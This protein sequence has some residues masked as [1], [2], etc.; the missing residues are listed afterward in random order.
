ML[1]LILVTIFF[2]ISFFA[3]Y[4]MN[5]KYKNIL[6]IILVVLALEVYVFN[7]NSYRTFFKNFEKK[8]FNKE[9]FIL[10]NMEYDKQTD[11]FKI[12]KGEESNSIIIDNIY[13]EIATIKIEGAGANTN[14]IEYSINYTDLTSSNF[15]SMPKKVLV[16]DLEKSKYTTCYLSGESKKIKINFQQSD[17]E[18]TFLKIDSIKINEK[19]PFDFSI[20][21]VITLIAISLLIYGM[22]RCELFKKSYSERNIKQSLLFDFLVATFILITLWI[23]TTTQTRNN[24]YEKYIDALSQGQANLLD[25]PSQKLISLENPY[26]MTQRKEKKLEY[27]WDVALYNNKYYVYF[28]IFPMLLSLSFKIITGKYL[29]LSYGIWI[30]NIITIISLAKL[31]KLLYKKWFN[32][33]SFNYLILALIGTISGS[34]IFWITRTSCIYEFVL[35]AG[36]ACSTLGICLMFK[37]IEKDKV[38]YKYL[39][40]SATSLALAVACRPNH[41]LVSLILIPIL[42]KILKN[43]I[44][45]KRDIVKL[46]LVVGIPYLVVGISLMVYNYIRFDSIFEF[47]TNY[48]LT[49]NDMKSL[50]NRIFT[51]PTG[52]ITQLFNLPTIITEFPFFVRQTGNVPFFGYYYEES[53]VCGLF[54]LNIINYILI[55]LIGLKK[56]I[57]EKQ[58]YNYTILFTIVAFIMSIVGILKAGSLQRYSMDYAWMLNIASYLTLFM[59]VSNIKSKEIKKYILKISIAVTLFMLFV[60]FIVGGVCGEVDLL[61]RTRPKDYY[62]IRYDICFWE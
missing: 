10:E 18:D 8:E 35:A 43:N 50:Q 37:A 59:I 55:F 17:T 7:F 28:G 13:T 39:C 58:A 47:G 14:N 16:N 25:E 31:I 11:M 4:K 27:I 60:N 5:F 40:L 19:V 23:A 3:L 48:Q 33:L 49:V 44:K 15:R 29:Q 57:K 38:N 41:L 54:V 45:E 56:K 32:N 22:L 6:R 61:K 53:V 30:F 12:K 9:S 21:R 24:I 51:I 20:V 46:I 34:L 1:N 26:D 52:L 62:N 2:A 36:V 42:I